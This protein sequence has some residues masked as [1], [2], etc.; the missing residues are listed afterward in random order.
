MIKKSIVGLIV[1]ICFL[2]S[3]CTEKVSEIPIDTEYVEAYDAFE[4]VY[5]YKYDWLHGDWRYL[6]VFKSVHHSEEYKVQYE[7]TYSDGSTNTYWC[8]VD[9]E[10]YEDALKQLEGK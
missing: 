3:G 4:T 6:P 10:T 1:I 2:L 7:V 9:K 8:T 5:E